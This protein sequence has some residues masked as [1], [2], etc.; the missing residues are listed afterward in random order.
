MDTYILSR[1]VSIWYYVI[2]SMIF[3]SFPNK[4]FS[5]CFLF[6]ASH[7]KLS[8]VRTKLSTEEIKKSLSPEIIIFW[9]N[10]WFYLE[11]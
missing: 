6:P 10:L 11:F 7:S 8:F 3:F 9:E 1:M 4:T 2:V 5:L